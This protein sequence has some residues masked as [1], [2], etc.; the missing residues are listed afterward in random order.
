[1]TIDST[2]L[3]A[4]IDARVAE[5]AAYDAAILALGTTGVQ[6]YTLDTGQ[7]RT[8]VTR[9]NLTELRNARNSLENDL[10][11]LCARKNGGTVTVRPYF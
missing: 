4:R 6:S 1:M 9:A 11:T 7:T 5:I 2:Y 8:V 10:E 3:Q